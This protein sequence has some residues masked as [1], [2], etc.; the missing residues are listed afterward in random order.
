MYEHVPGGDILGEGLSDLTA[1]VR[2]ACALLVLIGAPRLARH[3]IQI[4]AGVSRSALPEHELY[5]LLTAEHGPEAYRHY[6][7]LLRRLVS[8]ENALD[9]QS[10]TARTAAITE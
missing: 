2:S 9:C 4:P 5:D 3:G 10:E 1:G 6:R 8:L 7:S